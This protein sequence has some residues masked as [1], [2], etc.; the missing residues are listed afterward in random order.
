M[1]MFFAEDEP[2]LFDLFMDAKSAIR[3]NFLRQTKKCKGRTVMV[4][5][6]VKCPCCGKQNADKMPSGNLFC[7]QCHLV[8][9]EGFPIQN[10]GYESEGEV[11]L[12]T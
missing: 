11:F 10:I 12:C 7:P 1:K 2:M 8:D 4:R 3:E 6:K 9:P 5:E